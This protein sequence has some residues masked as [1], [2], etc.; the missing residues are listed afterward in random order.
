M[1]PHGM[2]PSIFLEAGVTKH[3]QFKHYYPTGGKMFKDFLAE[4]GEA[5]IPS[6]AKF[7]DRATELSVFELT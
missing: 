3:M 1:G 6:V 5:A 4:S 2:W 7:L